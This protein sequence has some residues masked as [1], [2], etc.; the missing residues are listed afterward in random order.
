MPLVFSGKNGF[1]SSQRESCRLTHG[2]SGLS[3]VLETR[4]ESFMLATDFTPFSYIFF[5]E[6]SKKTADGEK[7]KK[8]QTTFVQK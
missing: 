6:P 8:K 2:L 4:R 3:H 7:E 1:S 5:H